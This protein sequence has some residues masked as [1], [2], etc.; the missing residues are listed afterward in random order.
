MNSC[1]SSRIGFKTPCFAGVG[2]PPIFCWLY[3]QVASACLDIDELDAAVKWAERGIAEAPDG[4]RIH[5][6]LVEVRLRR[7][8]SKLALGPV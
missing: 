6:L 3:V 7:G 8:E 1:S 5:D 4:H 2:S